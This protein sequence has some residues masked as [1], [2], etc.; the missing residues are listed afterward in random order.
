MQV[1]V[2]NK[3]HLPCW[4][5]LPESGFYDPLPG[6]SPSVSKG[7]YRRHGAARLA[8]TSAPEAGGGHTTRRGHAPHL[9]ISDP[10]HHVTEAI[11]HMYDDDYDRNDPRRLSYIASPL[12]EA[13]TTIPRHAAGSDSSLSPS[14]PPPRSPISPVDGQPKQTNGHLRPPLVGQWSFDR[15]SDTGSPDSTRSPS[16]TATSSFPL[17]DIDYESDP[18]AVVQELNNLAAIRRMSMDQLFDSVPTP[19]PSAD[20][21]DASRLFWVPASLHPELAPKEFKSFLESKADVIKRKSGD[22]SSLGPERQGS[23]SGL[24]RKRSMLSKQIDDSSGYKD[25]ADR[26]ECQR[27][28]S[29]RRDGMLSPNLQELETLVDD[30]KPESKDSLVRGMQNAS[31]A[32]SEDKPILP[33]AP[34]GHSLRRSTRTQYK[35]GS[36]KKGEKVPYSKRVGRALSES[37]HTGPPAVVSFDD[38]PILGTTRVSTD[39]TS[40]ATGRAVRS[41]STS[42][43]STA[44]TPG[45]MASSTFDPILDNPEAEQQEELSSSHPSDA[46]FERS[47]STGSNAGSHGRQWHSRISSNGRS[48]LI[49]PP[50]EQQVPAIVETPPPDNNRTPPSSSSQPARAPD[51]DMPSTFSGKISPSH[52]STPSKRSL[53]N[54]QSGKD[55]TTTLDDFASQPQMIPGNSTRTDSLSFIP[56][57]PEERKSEG[58]KSKK[59]TEGRKS[60]WHWLLGSEEKDKKKEKDSDSKKTKSKHPDKSHNNARM[61]VLQSSMDSTP[62]GRESLIL[63]RLDPKLEEERRKDGVRRASGE[64][65]KEKDGIFSSIFGGGRKK[66]SGEGHHRKNSS[67]NL[68]PDP[69]MRELRADVDFPWTRFSILEERAI[70]RMAHIKLANPR[71]AL[72]SQVLLSNFMYSYLEKVQQMHPQMTVASSGSQRSSK[73]RDQPDEYLQYQRYQ[74]AQEQQQQQQQQQYGDSAYDDPSMY[75]YDDDP[76]DHYQA[77]GGNSKHGYENGHAYDSG[78]YQYGH[79]SFGDDVQLDDDDDDD[80]W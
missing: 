74:E 40:A 57:M 12:G 8:S 70:Y 51:R 6:L 71:R 55:S 67:R 9:S 38:Q 45:S 5:V 37:T 46:S 61:D 43:R 39:S 17:N 63:D 48:T 10:S 75:D 2:L 23:G 3:F 13:I 1:R 69:P 49:I 26:L 76:H 62:K 18:A 80:M 73:S 66:H 4:L 25:G 35:K 31:I 52:D 16:E 33:P 20:E 19:S 72:Y 64:S 11:G 41:P 29:S 21:N 47:D 77:Q 60:S 59:D 24:R 58:K 36:L 50:T 44:Y 42:S 78:H 32:A 22:Y 27:S 79:S 54:R 14:T 68:S 28:Q 53:M 34:P 15:D 7:P 56:T 65:K 30:S